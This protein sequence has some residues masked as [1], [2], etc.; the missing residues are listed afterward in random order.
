MFRLGNNKA[1]IKKIFKKI[2]AKDVTKNLPWLLIIA[3]PNDE[4]DIKII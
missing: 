3:D 2:G 4:S 1:I